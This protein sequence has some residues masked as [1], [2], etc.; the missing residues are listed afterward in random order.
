MQWVVGR[1]ECGV[2]KNRSN[3]RWNGFLYRIRRLTLDPSGFALH[4]I[5]RV[6]MR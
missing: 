2:Q 3:G 5:P 1:C 6:G 4:P